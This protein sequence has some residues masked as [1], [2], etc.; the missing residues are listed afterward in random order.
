MLLRFRIALSFLTRL[1][2][3]RH[4][5]GDA[6]LASSLAAF[7][8]VGA[9]VGALAAVVLAGAARVLPPEIAGAR[10]CAALALATG[11]L[12]LDGL[13]DTFDALGSGRDRDGRLEVMRDSR[14]GAHGATAL[15][16]VL[17]VEIACFAR[18]AAAGTEAV[19][20]VDA[21]VAV[22]RALVAVAMARHPYARTRG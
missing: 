21:A 14:I 1:P 10:A 3:G 13:A 18:L 8:L 15:A 16:L 17:V 9:V 7:P 11:G 22:A 19:A 5:V 6:D 4:P 12:H 2:G 20:G